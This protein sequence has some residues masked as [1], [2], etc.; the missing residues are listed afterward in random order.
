[1]DREDHNMEAALWAEYKHSRAKAAK[2][3]LVIYYLGYV[4]HICHR[5]AMELP[6]HVRADDL[7]SSGVVG[8]I[9]AIDKFDDK[10]DNLF[11]TYAFIRIRGAVYDDK[12]SDDGPGT[13]VVPPSPDRGDR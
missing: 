2:D 3:A 7:V 1:M 12:K 9:D 5:M 8:L 10:R 13:A 11:K 4:K 6:S